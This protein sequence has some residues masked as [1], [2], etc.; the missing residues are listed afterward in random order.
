LSPVVF[1]SY[2]TS[3]WTL[4]D[5]LA[6]ILTMVAVVFHDNNPDQY[7]QGINAFVL[8]LLWM[9][10]LGF[11]KGKDS[12]SRVARVFQATVANSF[13]LTFFLVVNKQMSTFILALF[14]ILH[15]IRYFAAVLVVIL[16]MFGDM[17]HIVSKRQPPYFV[18][19]VSCSSFLTHHGHFNRSQ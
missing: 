15:D 14:E 4:F 3:I 17:M 6:I 9:K 16:L 12:K 19:H 2:F 8:G 13:L 10:V 11:L 1:Q 18:W 7:R 5:I